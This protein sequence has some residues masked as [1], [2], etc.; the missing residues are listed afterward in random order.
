MSKKRIKKLSKDEIEENYEEYYYSD[1][2]EIYLDYLDD[3]YGLVYVWDFID[4]DNL[5]E[6]VSFDLDGW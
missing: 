2:I 5:P 3:Y 1:E 4:L 6:D